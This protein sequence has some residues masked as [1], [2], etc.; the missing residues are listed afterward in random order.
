MPNKIFRY[1]IPVDD[2]WHVLRLSGAVLHVATRK[3]DIVEMWAID[4]GGPQVDRAFIVVG[5]GHEFPNCPVKHR[6]TALFH[7][8]VW[9]LLEQL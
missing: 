6:G 2:R 9:H 4:T 7:S 1:E 3:I 8:A 5:T